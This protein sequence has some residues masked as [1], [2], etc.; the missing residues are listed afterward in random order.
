MWILLNLL[1]TFLRDFL[2]RLPFGLFSLTLGSK[3]G[4]LQPGRPGIKPKH[5]HSVE[6][7]I[8]F[9]LEGHL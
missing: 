4:C 7:E 3:Y 5:E 9:I 2:S 8:K 1:L 6:N